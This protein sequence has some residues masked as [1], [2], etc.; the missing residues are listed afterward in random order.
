MHTALQALIQVT[1]KGDEFAISAVSARLEHPNGAVRRVALQALAEIAS[2]GNQLAVSAASSSLEHPNEEVRRSALAALVNMATKGNKLG[3]SAVEAHL[4]HPNLDVRRSAL[5]MLAAVGV[6]GDEYVTSTWL[7][8]PVGILASVLEYL[9]PLR[10]LLRALAVCPRLLEVGHGHRELHRRWVALLA[11]GS[12]PVHIT[13]GLNFCR[14]LAMI[15]F[16]G[17]WHQRSLMDGKLLCQFDFLLKP[18]EPPEW[19]DLIVADRACT[20]LPQPLPQMP[21][22]GGSGRF[23]VVSKRPPHP[24]DP[25]MALRGYRGK[26]LFQPQS[27]WGDVI[28]FTVTGW[29]LGHCLCYEIVGGRLPWD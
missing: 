21:A 8:C 3:V 20:T 26:G 10:D 1:E 2:T 23:V 11:G 5:Q 12:A 27:M 22:G 28:S 4:Q 16:A 15:D 17:K 18:A 29:S 6:K 9:A 24:P 19:R 7:K 25:S 13:D 14:C